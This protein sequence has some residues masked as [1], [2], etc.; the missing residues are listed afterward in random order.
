MFARSALIALA[1]FVGGVKSLPAETVLPPSYF[2]P[3][4][5]WERMARDWVRLYLRRPP[6]ERE[7]LMI[8]NQLRRGVSVNAV[9]ANILASAEYFR[10]CQW[11]LNVWARQMI[12]DVL[13]RPATPAE[14]ALV[15]NIAL[16]QGRYAAA[17]TTL[18]SQGGFWWGW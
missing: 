3:E 13:G 1:L 9:Q 10:G 17:L 18:E 5:R 12:A 14:A 15:T 2:Y 7:I 6:T 16:R 8:V 11:N 4:R